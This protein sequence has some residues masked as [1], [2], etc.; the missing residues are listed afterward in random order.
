MEWPL[1]GFSGNSPHPSKSVESPPKSRR[2]LLVEDD[3]VLRVLLAQNLEY[4]GL[5]YTVAS[6]GQQGLEMALQESPDL[7]I[8]D[9]EMPVL[10][11]F[12]FL[13]ALRADERV[14]TIPVIVLSVMVEEE[15]HQRARALGAAAFI[16]KSCTIKEIMDA[17]KACLGGG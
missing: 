8:T 4:E 3:Q 10:D 5:V 6:D 7:I 11:G 13:Q 9:L 12:A 15:H 2:I 17:I 1:F 16:N 14:R